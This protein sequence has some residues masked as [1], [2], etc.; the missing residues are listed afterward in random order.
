LNLNSY[1]RANFDKWDVVAQKA[2]AELG[3]PRRPDER[4]A[5]Y[6]ASQAR[7]EAQLKDA[8][9]AQDK[10]ADNALARTKEEN[11]LALEAQREKAAAI[12][13]NLDRINQVKVAEIAA[14]GHA[15]DRTIRAEEFNLRQKQQLDNQAQGHEEKFLAG[16]QRAGQISNQGARVQMISLERNL[17]SFYTAAINAENQV[18]TGHYVSPN[19][20]VGLNIGPLS[21]GGGVNVSN[22]TMVQYGRSLHDTPEARR[23]IQ[24]LDQIRQFT[25]RKI[26][27]EP[28]T[29]DQAHLLTDRLGAGPQNQGEKEWVKS[30]LA[31]KPGAPPPQWAAG[32]GATRSFVDAFNA[33]KVEDP[34]A[35]YRLAKIYRQMTGK[36]TLPAGA[37]LDSIEHPFGIDPTGQPGQGT[38]LPPVPT[39][40]PLAPYGSPPANPNLQ[41]PAPYG[42][43]PSGAPLVGPHQQGT[44]GLQDFMIKR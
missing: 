1:E 37:S 41:K 34:F 21:I 32:I 5:D 10:I 9:A 13:K 3:R 27:P 23:Y 40:G 25:G 24:A 8:S 12:Q 35:A 7:A 4:Y 17:H 30:L 16:V 2:Q 36:D 28:Q 33:L 29:P 19:G 39:S 18:R 31:G 14:T 6:T 22:D 38:E 42:R 26:Q 44:L 15:S 43:A 11:R 20:R